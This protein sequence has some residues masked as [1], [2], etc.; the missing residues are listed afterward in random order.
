LEPDP[1]DGNIYWEVPKSLYD[2][3]WATRRELYKSIVALREAARADEQRKLK[4]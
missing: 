4:T 3:Y 2:R 1:P